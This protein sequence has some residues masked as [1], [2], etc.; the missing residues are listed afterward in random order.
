MD[1]FVAQWIL[2]PSVLDY[3][4]DHVA[5]SLSVLSVWQQRGC[6]ERVFLY[7]IWQPVPATWMVDVTPVLALKQQAMQC[8]QLPLKYGDYAAA[9]FGIMRYRGVYL[10]E[11]SEK[12]A[13]AFLELEVTSW[14]SVLS[15]LFRL[16]G[17]QEEFL[18]SLELITDVT[19]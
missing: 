9:F 18:H 19:H 1:T 7:E 3:H 12:Y 5:I 17:Y 2:L 16:R 15:Q 8:Y 13:E 11:Q 4:R 6:Q 14:Q 10:G